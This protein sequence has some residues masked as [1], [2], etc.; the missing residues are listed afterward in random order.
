MIRIK[1][2]FCGTRDHSEFTYGGDGSIIYPNI[3]A[4]KE[5][6]LDAVFQR[7]NTRGMQKETWHHVNGC[8]MWLIVERDTVTHKIKTVKPAHPWYREMTG[9]KK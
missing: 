9:I 7:E 3:D 5:E 1:C 4:P 2:P 8:R 6:W